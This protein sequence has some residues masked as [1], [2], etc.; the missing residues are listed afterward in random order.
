MKTRT[1]ISL[2]SLFWFCFAVFSTHLHADT[3][4]ETIDVSAYS[5]VLIPRG[6]G[7]IASTLSDHNGYYPSSSQSMQFLLF[8][9]DT[10]NTALYVQTEDAAANIAYWE[11][12]H[13]ASTPTLTLHFYSATKPNIVQKSLAID[14]AQPWVAAAE[15]YKKWAFKQSWAKLKPSRFDWV[16][17]V[18]LGASNSFSYM[19]DTSTTP[20]GGNIGP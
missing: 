12:K 15:E 19:V 3:F 16:K 5:K 9:N 18:A 6:L 11:L 13:P 7:K 17:I 2:F 8:Y 14:P 10:G 1:G 20:Y 4:T